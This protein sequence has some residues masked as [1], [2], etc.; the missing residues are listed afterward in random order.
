[1]EEEATSDFEKKNQILLKSV[2]VPPQEKKNSSY[3]KSFVREFFEKQGLAVTGLNNYLT[4]KLDKVEFIKEGVRVVDYKTGKPKSRNYI[5]GKTKQ[6]GAGDYWRQLVFYKLLLD[7]YQEGKYRMRE[8]IIDFIE[9]NKAGRYKQE[10]F[11][12]EKSELVGLEKLIKKTADEI[13]NLKFWNR[14]CGDK[15]CQFCHL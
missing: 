7:R 15:K 13:L 8:G 1:M 9:P 2:F 14:R 3:E 12:I 10:N 6:A 4:G 11:T 5:L